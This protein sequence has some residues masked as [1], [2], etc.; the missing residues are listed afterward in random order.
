[1]DELDTIIRR[2]YEDSIHG[3]LSDERFMKLSQGYEQE[4]KSLQVQVE[5]LSQSIT[6]QEQQT[7]NVER[8]LKVIRKYGDVTEVTPTM[9]HE[10]IE[11]IEIYEPDKSSGRRVVKVDISLCYIGVVEKLDFAG[12][13]AA[14]EANA[15]GYSAGRESIGGNWSNLG[16]T[17]QLN[18]C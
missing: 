8:F 17:L 7:V 1:M 12:A 14:E 3:K 6:A 16:A 2:L 13:E 15:N 4:Q 11:R 18:P 5:E 10:L 9:L